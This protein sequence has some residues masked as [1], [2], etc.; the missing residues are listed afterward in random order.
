VAAAEPRVTALRERRHPPS[1]RPSDPPANPERLVALRTWLAF[2][3]LAL[4]ATL[5]WSTMLVGSERGRVLLSLA[6]ALMLAGGLRWL[7]SGPQRW[8]SASRLWELGMLGAVVLAALALLGIAGFP[9]HLLFELRLAQFGSALSDGISGVPGL[10]V[11]YIGTDPRVAAAL[12]LAGAA[13]LVAASLVLGTAPRTPGPGRLSLTALPL[14]ILA[15]VPSAIVTPR[16]V[17]LHGL[18][19]F[20]LVALLVFA[21]RLTLVRMGAAGLLVL[22][23]AAIGTLGAGVIPG[24]QRWTDLATGPGGGHG[25]TAGLAESFNWQQTYGTLGWPY[26]GATVLRVNAATP[27]LW[28]AE[29]L[30][31]FDGSAWIQTTQPSMDDGDL[32]GVSGATIAKWTETLRVRVAALN[33]PDVIAAGYANAPDVPGAQPGVDPGTWVTSAPLAPGESYTAMVYAPHPTAAALQAAGTDYPSVITPF[34]SPGN[35]PDGP[36]AGVQA[37]AQ[38]LSVGLTT[39]YEYVTAVLDYLQHGYVYTLSPPP[40]GKYPLAQFL[41]TSRQGYCQQFAGAMAL[42]LRM[43]GVPARV[44][45]GF[46]TGARQKNSDTYVVADQDA[47][48]WVEVWFPHMGWVSFDPTPGRPSAGAGSRV[49]SGVPPVSAAAAAAAAAAGA[50]TTQPSGTVTTV[51]QIQTQT[52]EGQTSST[53]AGTTAP[54]HPDS[55]GDTVLVI[56]A[57]GIVGALALVLLANLGLAYLRR[58]SAAELAAEIERAFARCGRPLEAELTLTALAGDLADNPAAAAYVSALADVRYGQRR[59]GP[60]AGGRS[61]LRHWLAR[62]NGP[63][64]WLRA[65][66]ALPPRRPVAD[67]GD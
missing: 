25:S 38:R 51:P 65:L 20:L 7:V 32:D 54:T 67:P 53:A 10:L 37:L 27:T 66:W 36:Y 46:S 33:S 14:V 8:L 11:P 30:D 45:V 26:T 4:Y 41:L 60:A 29:D 57:L 50:T 52:V 62:G 3:A 18:V 59:P 13:L 21:P 56:V 19:T 58:P 22:A 17:S 9:L 48:A 43:K 31:D 42:L 5:R 39:P 44:A 47:H 35:L 6:V 15:V 24:D 28:K 23:A 16:Y 2:G 1:A 49:A 61:A 34:R 12:V 63:L 64:G 55:G 40:G